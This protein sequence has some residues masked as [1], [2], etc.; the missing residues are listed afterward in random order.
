MKILSNM[1]FQKI[2]TQFRF[3][4]LPPTNT[5]RE[6]LLVASAHFPPL[7]HPNKL[8]LL[9]LKKKCTA[10]HLFKLKSIFSPLFSPPTI[11]KY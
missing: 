3:N 4:I 5:T 6:Y 11:L 1:L 10:I 2:N 8:L 9:M 7:V